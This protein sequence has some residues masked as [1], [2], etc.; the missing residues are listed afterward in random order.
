[1]IS[2]EN[3]LKEHVF[4]LIR[5]SSGGKVDIMGHFATKKIS[6]ST[7]SNTELMAMPEEILSTTMDQR[8]CLL[9]EHGGECKKFWGKKRFKLRGFYYCPGDLSHQLQKMK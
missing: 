7:A 2:K 4:H 6:H 3:L 5:S 8:M 9:V 1:M